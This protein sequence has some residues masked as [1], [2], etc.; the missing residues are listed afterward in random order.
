MRYKN[1]LPELHRAAFR[2][3]LWRKRGWRRNKAYLFL[4]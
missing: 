3:N 2:V 4:Q 1:Y